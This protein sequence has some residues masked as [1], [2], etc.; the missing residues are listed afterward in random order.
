MKKCKYRKI[1]I[2]KFRE[3]KKTEYKKEYIQK[4]VNIVIEKYIFQIVYTKKS[5][6]KKNIYKKVYTEESIYK[7]VYTWK[8]YK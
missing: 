4:K 7:K 5:L 6:Y 2:E 3:K 1:Y 8:K